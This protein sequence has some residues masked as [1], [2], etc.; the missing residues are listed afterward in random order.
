MDIRPP[1][2]P[3]HRQLL[4]TRLIL[5]APATGQACTPDRAALLASELAQLLD[6][7]QTEGLGFDAL[8]K[9]VPEDYARHWQ[10]TLDFLSILTRHWPVILESM[11]CLDPAEHRN[12]L[13]LARA[14]AWQTTPPSGPVLAAGITGSIPAVASLLATITTLPQGRVVLPGLDRDLDADS[15][16]AIDESHPQHALKRLLDR[17][18]KKRGVVFKKPVLVHGVCKYLNNDELKSCP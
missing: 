8:E 15:W 14:R 10:I 18:G 9:L 16:E 6:Q 5:A 4:L 13:L 3:L 11:G 7:V 1:I 12:R 17:L 2:S